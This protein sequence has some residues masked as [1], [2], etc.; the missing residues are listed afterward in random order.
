MGIFSLFS[1]QKS[2]HIYDASREKETLFSQLD[3]DFFA[4]VADS[5]DTMMLYFLQGEGWI[6]ANKT[7]FNT[8]NYYDI[9]DPKSIKMISTDNAKHIV[10]VK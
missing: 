9:K 1:K 4:E 6:G 8:M 10:D 7:F 3:K 2:V 5:S